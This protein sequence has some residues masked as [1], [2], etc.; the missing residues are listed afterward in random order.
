MKK[1]VI[2]AAAFVFAGATATASAAVQQPEAAPVA[3]A[4]PVATAAPV[5][6]VTT[7]APVVAEHPKHTKLR[8][9]KE[10]DIEKL[11]HNAELKAQKARDI[12]S[13][14]CKA[15]IEKRTSAAN[16]ALKKKEADI[17]RK[18]NDEI[19]N[20]RAAIDRKYAVKHAKVDTAK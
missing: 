1:L 14:D 9:E 17:D 7:A 2:V 18:K 3:A 20:G 15:E 19:R 5:A 11:E 12:A 13:A 8:A 4:A 10:R 16:L 6:P